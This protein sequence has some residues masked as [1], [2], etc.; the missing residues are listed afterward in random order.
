MKAEKIT[1]AH[2]SRC[3]YIY[4]RQ[5][6]VEQVRHH[7]E[8]QRLQYQLVE[9][10]HEYGWPNPE[11]IDEDLGRS[12]CGTVSRPGFMRL[13]SAVAK[14]QVGAIFCLEASRLTRNPREWSQLIE[15]YSYFNTLIIDTGG[16]HDPQNQGERMVF[17]IQGAVFEFETSTFRQRAHSAIRAKAE[18]GEFYT[19]L[20]A[21]YELTPDKKNCINDPNQ[22]VQEALH[23]IFDKF[24]Q[25]G[26]ARSV[27]A[28]LQNE[29]IAVPCRC[30]AGKIFWKV[31]T[32]SLLK[33]IL[34]NP[35]YAGAY[36]YGRSQTVIRI[37]DDLPAK[38]SCELPRDQWKVLIK[39]HHPPYITWD[40]YMSN[41][42]RLLQ[43]QNKRGPRVKGA[44]KHGS[45]LLTGLLH[46]QRC[47][48][49]FRVLYSAAT[50]RT[51]RYVCIGQENKG[52]PENCL[53]F[54]GATLEQLVTKL[55]FQV[56]EPAAIAAAEQATSL[57][58]QQKNE[59]IR[60][61]R[62]QLSQAQYEAVRCFE[63]YNLVDPKNRLVAQNLETSW[64]QSLEKQKQLEQQLHQLEQVYQP[65][66]AA[67]RQAIQQLAQNLPATW[68]H[69][70]ADNRIKKRILQTL[71]EAIWVKNTP[72]NQLEITIHWTGGVHT[73]HHLQRRQSPRRPNYLQP[74]T[75][76]IIR[77]LAEIETD[78]DIARNLNLVKIQTAGGKNWTENSVRDFRHR[79]K[80]PVF[81]PM[82]YQKKGWVNNVR[83][84]LKIVLHFC[85][86]KRQVMPESLPDKNIQVQAYRA[87]VVIYKMDFRQKRAGMTVI[88]TDDG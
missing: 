22:Q 67:D 20:P 18:R 58:E 27:V 76:N 30:G 15:F 80:I 86:I 38:S 73:Q 3:A 62:N 69:P 9:L 39:D 29:N 35:I 13:L 14:E 72:E 84:T 2:L 65:L 43:N 26:S 37:V 8:S 21:G 60:L 34:T 12:G 81:N 5:S 75:E 66:S 49:K 59:K 44:P 17:G 87:S 6:T 33:K 53:S 82:E 50:G 88:G 7:L 57:L 83:H 77:A 61:V 25:L 47:G 52:Q 51:P 70:A 19:N 36:A 4:I 42:N 23:F 24:Q 40:Q 78:A 74:D 79:H 46:C 85:K 68:Y 10:A 32:A 54:A 45:A 31:P 16:I 1:I 63:Q 56:V 55:V 41:Q 71:I 48:Q 64:N 11:I 28:C